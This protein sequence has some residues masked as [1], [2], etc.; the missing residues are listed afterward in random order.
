MPRE[1]K[2]AL[3]AALGLI[4]LGLILSIL[5]TVRVVQIHQLGKISAEPE[6]IDVA[7][8][9]QRGATGNAHVRVHGF[10]FGKLYI[11]WRDRTAPNEERN[12]GLWRHV[13]IPIT[14][15][16]KAGATA[17]LLKV[18]DVGSDV[19]MNDWVAK[20]SSVQGIVINNIDPIADDELRF[21]QEKYP[22]LD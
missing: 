13:W 17:V 12:S 6:D 14:P 16:G 2:N 21:L 3:Q 18:L 11:V 7:D 8:L 1:K 5:C 15:V 10:D 19:Q 9:I 4:A 22:D 20:R